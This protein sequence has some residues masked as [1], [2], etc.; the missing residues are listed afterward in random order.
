MRIAL[1]CLAAATLC[2]G[3]DAKAVFQKV[4]GSC[5]AAEAV[6]TPRSR[7]Q[8]Q[9]TIA[10]MIDGGANATDDERRIV[11]DY[12]VAQ[13]GPSAEGAGGRGG[14]G[15]GGGG[16][17]GGR[18]TAP[19]G[20]N[21]PNA[22]ALDRHVVDAAGADRGRRVWAAECITCHGTNARG[23][24]DG[25]NLIQSELILHDRYGSHLGPFLRKGHPMQSG[26]SSAAITQAQVADL[27]HFIH[28]RLYDTLR[29][30]PIFVPG[31]VVTGDARA[32]AAWFSG[33]GKCSTCHSA[34]GDLA[35]IGA[36]YDPPTLQGRFLF[37]R[38]GGRGGRG[39][40]KQM[41]VTVTP[42][43]GS[44]VSGVPIVFDD[45]NIS[46]RDAAGDYHSFTRAPAL[47]V[48]RNDPF[49]V[50]DELLETYTDKNMHDM[51][52]Y[53]VTLK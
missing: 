39:G 9:E 22:G 47:K 35:K 27:S 50:H 4:C 3:Q 43:N 34:T 37:P 38:A 13:H 25:A 19:A 41:T 8:W 6:V 12:L 53:L 17:G 49:A 18:G 51:L 48:V 42:P 29:G 31:N 16:R 40:G 32:G 24:G 28:D 10:K 46:L 26:G 30:S 21:R 14:R 2:R 45:F 7:Q 44:S 20:V 52:A 36:R 11:L 33:A 5:H 1:I 15:G 23:T